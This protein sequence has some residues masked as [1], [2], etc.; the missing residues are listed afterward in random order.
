[1][2]EEEFYLIDLKSKFDKIKPN[3]YYLSYSGGKDSHFLYWF[4][5]EYLK[6]DDIKIVGINTYMEH[7]EIRDRIIKELPNITD[8]NFDGI[9]FDIC[10]KIVSLARNYKGK[11]DSLVLS[12]IK[13]NKNEKIDQ[14]SFY[15]GQAQKWLNMTLKYMYLLGFWDDDLKRFS[16]V[17]HVPIDNYIIEAVW[18]EGE[19]ENNKIKLKNKIWLIKIPSPYGDSVRKNK[20]NQEIIISWSKWS[21]DEYKD[22]QIKL[23]K[24][25]LLEGKSPL[26]WENDIWIKI[27][28]SK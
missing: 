23:R 9:H 20:Y 22:F 1:M 4:I 5:K 21:E 3:T 6:R 18:H 13:N 8:K 26:E 7:H 27:A 15:Y 17:L 10:N 12:V 16:K 19:T 11:T 2:D 14:K 24:H 25:P 28:S